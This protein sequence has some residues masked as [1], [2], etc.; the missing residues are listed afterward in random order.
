MQTRNNF[1]HLFMTQWYQHSLRT[2]ETTCVA[3]AARGYKVTK[4]LCD[5]NACQRHFFHKGDRIIPYSHNIQRWIDYIIL[6]YSRC[7]AFGEYGFVVQYARTIFTLL[8]EWARRLE[9]T[10]SQLNSI[11]SFQPNFGCYLPIRAEGGGGL[12]SGSVASGIVFE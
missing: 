6:S 3:V 12:A 10:P 8:H 9:G 5:K 1:S 7:V 4:C 2:F 11:A